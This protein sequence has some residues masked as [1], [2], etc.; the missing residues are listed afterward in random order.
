MQQSI[1]FIQNRYPGELFQE[2]RGGLLGLFGDEKEE[3]EEKEEEE[4]EDGGRVG[5]GG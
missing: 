1:R 3:D 2:P 5:G 4:E